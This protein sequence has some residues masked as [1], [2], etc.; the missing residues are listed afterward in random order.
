MGEL[1]STTSDND[2]SL[3][4]YIYF[5]FYNHF[6]LIQ[7]SVISKL[8]DLSTPKVVLNKRNIREIGFHVIHT[9]VVSKKYFS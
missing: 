1:T 6:I 5:L 7:F 4:N 9:R 8:S 2:K 3:D